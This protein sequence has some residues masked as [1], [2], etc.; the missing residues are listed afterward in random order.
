MRDQDC[1]AFLQKLLPQIGLRWPGYR[2]VRRTVC[3]RLTR[4][5]RA[6]DLESLSDYGNLILNDPAEREHFD[7]LC[8]IPISRFYRDKQVFSVLGENLL[9]DLAEAATARGARCVRA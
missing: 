2:K 7:A 1:V 9:P 3:K 8:R 4:R 6:L 5:L